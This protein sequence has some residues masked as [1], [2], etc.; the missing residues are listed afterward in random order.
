MAKKAKQ[1][2]PFN[3]EVI[4]RKYSLLTKDRFR[5]NGLPKEIKQ[6][7]IEN[8]LYLK[9][10][11]FFYFDNSINKFVCLPCAPTGEVNIYG[12]YLGVQVF[13][14]GFNKILSMTDGVWLR[15]NIDCYPSMNIVEFYID[16]II[17]ADRLELVNIEQQK[18][19]YIIS[20]TKDNLLSVKNFLEKAK[21]GE[22]EVIVDKTFMET[23]GTEGIKPMII[24]PPYLLDKIP[25]YRRKIEQELLTYLGINNANTEK[26]ERMLEDEVN[27][28]NEEVQSQIE[29]DLYTRKLACKMINEKFGLNVTVEINKQEVKGGILI[30]DNNRVENSTTE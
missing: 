16:K 7:Y 15:N 9:G 20:A 23:Q 30:N 25:I 17:K 13:G 3:E 2:F 21:Q 18:V 24:N 27:V 4:R 12:E 1:D 29:T 22:T 14:F 8:A 11:C 6:E 19:P 5:W 10:Q 26:R 28:N